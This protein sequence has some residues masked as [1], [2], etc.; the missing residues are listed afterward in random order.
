MCLVPKL[1]IT[2]VSCGSSL[3]SLR[4]VQASLSG[5]G[6]TMN[7]AQ[8]LDREVYDDEAFIGNEEGE[9]D[10]R[11]VDD[12]NDEGEIIGDCS[13]DIVINR[14]AASLQKQRQGP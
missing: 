6:V 7:G 8:D 4:A 11:V 14:T 5:S 1:D 12:L 9:I 3:A 2:L 10:G 13:T